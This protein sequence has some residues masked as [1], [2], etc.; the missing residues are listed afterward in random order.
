MYQRSRHRLQKMRMEENTYFF[1]DNEKR[2][3]KTLYRAGGANVLTL[4][5]QCTTEQEEK[6]GKKYIWLCVCTC[7][8]VHAAVLSAFLSAGTLARAV[9]LLSEAPPLL[10]DKS[11]L[12][13]PLWRHT[14]LRRPLFFVPRHVWRSCFRGLVTKLYC[15]PNIQ[16]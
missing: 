1:V 10:A 15:L 4:Q 12:V 3:I 6:G 16:H 9:V 14:H 8:C 11:L 5:V 2:N 7:L 13:V